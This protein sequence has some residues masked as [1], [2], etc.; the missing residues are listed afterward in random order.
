MECDSFS[1]LVCRRSP[2]SL[3][4]PCSIWVKW[5]W[6]G[7]HLIIIIGRILDQNFR[8]SKCT[9]RSP[10]VNNA[11]ILLL[12]I[13]YELPYAII[14][15]H[16]EYRTQGLQHNFFKEPKEAELYLLTFNSHKL[17]DLPGCRSSPVDKSNWPAWIRPLV[18]HFNAFLRNS[19]VYV[20]KKRITYCYEKKANWLGKYSHSLSEIPDK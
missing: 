16:F 1:V 2:S 14:A 19:R 5:I 17:L 15:L 18:K 4:L 13:N 8:R 11:L 12:G 9:L 3:N 10:M 6:R 20:R 7:L